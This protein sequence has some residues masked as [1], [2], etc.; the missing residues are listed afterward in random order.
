MSLLPFGEYI[1]KVGKLNALLK[2]APTHEAFINA[3][4]KDFGYV[5]T[6]LSSHIVEE[7]LEFKRRCKKWK[8]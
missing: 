8:R 3:L 7:L 6:F 2:T 4:L 1:I 5:E